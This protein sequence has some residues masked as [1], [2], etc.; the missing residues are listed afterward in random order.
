[1]P[2]PASL[3]TRSQVPIAE[4]WDLFSIFPTA[5]AWDTSLPGADRRPAGSFRLPGAVERSSQNPVG[6]HNKI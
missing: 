4:T 5:D 1:M 3:P 6:V 2:E